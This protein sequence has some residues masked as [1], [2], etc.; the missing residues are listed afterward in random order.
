MRTPWPDKTA[1]TRKPPAGQLAG[2]RFRLQ[3]FLIALAVVLAVGV[4]GFMLIEGLSFV[5][6]V[7]FTVITIGTVGYGD[8][9]PHTA[10]GKML[11]VLVIIVGVGTFVGVLGNLTD[12]FILR[13][14]TASRVEKMNIMIG[15]FFSEVGRDLLVQFAKADTQRREMSADLSLCAGW[16]KGDFQ[17]VTA[18]LSR[19]HYRV[20]YDAMD[21][22]A[23]RFL[24]S[25]KREFLVRLIEN[26]N[27]VEHEAFTDL[28]RAVFHLADELAHRPGF[29]SLPKNDTAHLVGD[30]RRAYSPLVSQWL[31]QMLYLETNY[32]YL[33]SLAVRTNPFDQDASVVIE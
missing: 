27:L 31:E 21:F 14:E 32:P 2:V 3:V 6:A 16:K 28:L 7:Y 10:L 33:F 17:R 19:F 25:A 24:L 23:V 15:A 4:V 29:D 12:L 30:V 26:P 11:A 20:E 18:G 8:I 13:R 5:D 9:A 22:E 1:K